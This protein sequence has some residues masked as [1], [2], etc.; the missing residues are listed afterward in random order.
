[1][2]LPLKICPEVEIP[3]VEILHNRRE[4]WVADV[5]DLDLAL[6]ALDHPIREHG[7]KTLT[8]E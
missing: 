5:V 4:H 8:Q 3:S 7:L 1:M 6:F 2:L